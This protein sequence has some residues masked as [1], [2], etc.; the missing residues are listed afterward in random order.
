MPR[1]ATDRRL[2][3]AGR[4]AGTAAALTVLLW[5]GL[6]GSARASHSILDFGKHTVGTA[7]SPRA[8]KFTLDEPDTGPH[9][10]AFLG[11]D[12]QVVANSCAEIRALVTKFCDVKVVFAP[13]STG[14][15]SVNPRL[16]LDRDSDY[17]VGWQSSSTYYTL[18]GDALPHY[19]PATLTP[20]AHD[21]GAEFVGG[22][23]SRTFIFR[24]SDAPSSKLK[25]V[26]VH[27]GGASFTID[28]DTC[29]FRTLK[30]VQ[31]C[32]VVVSFQPKTLGRKTGELVVYSN[33]GSRSAQ[34]AGSGKQRPIVLPPPPPPPP[35]IGPPPPVGTIMWIDH[36]G[37]QPGDATVQTSAQGTTP[38]GFGFA[39]LVVTSTTTGEVSPATGSRKVVHRALEV[40]PGYTVKGVRV[41]YE[42]SN[43][44]TFISRIGLAQVANPPTAATVVL[45]D[46]TDRTNL[47]PICID[48]A[49][50]TVATTSGSILLSLQLNFGDIGDSI[51]IRGVGIRLL[52]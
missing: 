27:S 4:T 47:G 42:L 31:K 34:F 5:V 46:D 16:H 18:T 50:T 26:V 8:L 19:Q 22:K 38:A 41:C 6:A 37:L 52:G 20:A 29:A 36:F 24:A 45:D 43:S 39:G 33:R 3:L 49:E 14:A 17:F 51:V 12:F 30:V 1:F 23:V 2:A 7:S 13:V 35:P 25:T 21:F 44:R 32:K 10:V 9:R 15:K 11:Q 48:S 28:S 40:P